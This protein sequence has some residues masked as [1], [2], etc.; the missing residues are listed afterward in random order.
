MANGSEGSG[1]QR[2]PQSLPKSLSMPAAP[3]LQSVFT[4]ASSTTHSGISRVLSPKAGDVADREDATW[5]GHGV[6]FQN[7]FEG[8]LAQ[9]TL[10]PKKFRG[11]HL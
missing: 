8:S 6:M 7:Y 2:A 3:N 10:P 1:S 9:P 11:F 5:Q 4:A